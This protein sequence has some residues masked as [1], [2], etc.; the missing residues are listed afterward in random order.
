MTRSEI[1]TLV[2]QAIPF[3]SRVE[4]AGHSDA[5][6]ESV[7]VYAKRRDGN[8]ASVAFSFHP[9]EHPRTDVALV[10]SEI[11]KA[12]VRLAAKIKPPA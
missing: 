7:F 10:Q 8:E 1:D 9:E 12:K 4:W 11:A 3:C 5:D 2:H 6:V